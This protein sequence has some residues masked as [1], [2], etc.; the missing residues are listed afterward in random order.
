M[1]SEHDSAYAKLL[2]QTIIIWC[3]VPITMVTTS[4]MV[5]MFNMLCRLMGWFTVLPVQSEIMM[6]WYYEAPQWLPNWVFSSMRM[7]F[8]R[9]LFWI[10]S[11]FSLFLE[12][13]ILQ[14]CSER[15]KGVQIWLH[16]LVP[17]QSYPLLSYCFPNMSCSLI[18]M[19]ALDTLEF[20]NSKWFKNLKFASLSPRSHTW[21]LQSCLFSSKLKLTIWQVSASYYTKDSW[22]FPDKGGIKTKLNF[23]S[24]LGQAQKCWI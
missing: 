16:F 6:P 14:I 5:P 21:A 13:P 1:V 4:T 24:E 11:L 17:M 22:V 9:H 20:Q 3:S 12:M 2:V 15:H 23:N 8:R 18:L 7:F 19:G 10:K